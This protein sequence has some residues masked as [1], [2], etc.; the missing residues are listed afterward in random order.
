MSRTLATAKLFSAAVTK[1]IRIRPFSS[2]AAAAASTTVKKAPVSAAASMVKKTGE[3]GKQSWIPDRE[4]DSTDPSTSPRRST[5][6]S[7]ALCSSGNTE[8]DAGNK[9]FTG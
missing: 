8:F 2:S 1:A 3:E 5:P 4:P 7:Y 9:I 6:S